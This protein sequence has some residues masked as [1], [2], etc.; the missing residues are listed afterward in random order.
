MG[1][2][3][4]LEVNLRHALVGAIADLSASDP[5]AAELSLLLFE[6]AQILDGDLPDDPAAFAGRI[7]RFALRGL[8]K[9]DAKT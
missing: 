4:I 2:K 1:L 8:G 5:E 7:N 3:P 9:G 6:Q